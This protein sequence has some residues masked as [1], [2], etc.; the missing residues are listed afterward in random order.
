MSSDCVPLPCLYVPPGS[1]ALL[2]MFGTAFSFG[3]MFN[4]SSVGRFVEKRVTLHVLGARSTTSFGTSSSR[5]P[6]LKMMAR[7][8]SEARKRAA[9]H[10]ADELNRA[11]AA[12]ATQERR[13]LSEN[14]MAA[15]KVTTP[16]PTHSPPLSTRNLVDLLPLQTVSNLVAAI[17]ADPPLGS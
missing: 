2:I 16:S 8:R 13:R 11:R 9:Q 4:I 15:M 7:V 10:Q 12:T 5:R 3:G 17:G 1:R 6:Q 14:T